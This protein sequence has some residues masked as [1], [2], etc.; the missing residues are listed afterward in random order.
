MNTEYEKYNKLTS[1]NLKKEV[2]IFNFLLKMNNNKINF[3]ISYIL[4]LSPTFLIYGINILYFIFLTLLHYFFVWCFLIKKT[5]FKLIS[6]DEKKEI[7]QSID[8]IN[9]ILKKRK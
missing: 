9:N 6:D 8:I 2:R 7:E 4:I 3:L 5:G 1:K